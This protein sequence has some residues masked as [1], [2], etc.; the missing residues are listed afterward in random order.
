MRLRK[1]KTKTTLLSAIDAALLAVEV[2]NKPRTTFRSEAYIAMMVIAWTRLFHAYF[3][4]IIGDR[5]YY[6]EK[7]SN[8]YQRIDGERKAWELATCISE[9]GKLNEPTKKNLEFFIKLRNKIEHRHIDKREVDVLIFG[10]C[11][12][13]LYNFESMLVDTFGQQYALN[14]SL[15][16]S[17]QFSHL[18][19]T[20]Q[21]FANKMALTGD[22]KDVVGY[23][24]QYRS[25]L[26]DEV[27]GSQEYSVRL[28]QIPKISN[29][30]KSDLA[31]EFV[32]WDELSEEDQEAFEKIRAIIKD[33]RLKVEGVNVGKLKR[34]DVVRRVKE[35][36]PGTT[37]ST[38]T[39]TCLFHLLK[40]RPPTNAENPFETNTTYCHND[41]A[42][43]D[44]LYRHEWPEL[45][46]NL[47]QSGR[48]E[49]DEIHTAKKN[50]EQWDI[51]ELTSMVQ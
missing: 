44:Y 26:A 16:Y 21:D 19:T 48:L 29:T 1:G 17:L 37:F 49:V 15:V 43:K 39:H 42:H 12:A 38:H 51:E 9:Y 28:L 2:Y 8:K 3:N 30:K 36:L 4:I 27:F 25:L 46:V 11:Q 6:R 40:I 45:I 20:E 35:A 10:E 41:E 23:V 50:N 7:D 18:R 14:E 32:R 24:E 5:Y 13:L 33:K 31:I 34:D 22:L 47:L